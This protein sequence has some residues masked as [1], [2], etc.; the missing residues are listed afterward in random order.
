MSS[1][2]VQPSARGHRLVVDLE[3]NGRPSRASRNACRTA[4]YGALGVRAIIQASNFG[5]CSWHCRR[6]RTLEGFA[7]HFRGVVICDN[8]RCGA[9]LRITQEPSPIAVSLQAD[10]RSTYIICPRCSI[11]TVVELEEVDLCYLPP[12][13]SSKSGGFASGS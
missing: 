4:A 7:V 9:I 5:P 1:F 8:A 13:S 11:R 10:D 12:M 3:A 6:L 2:I